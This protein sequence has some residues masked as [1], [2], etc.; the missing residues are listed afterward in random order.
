MRGNSGWSN[1]RPPST[2]VWLGFFIVAPVY[3]A[4]S[5]VRWVISEIREPKRWKR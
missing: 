5:P 1:M 2:A 4:L 3:W